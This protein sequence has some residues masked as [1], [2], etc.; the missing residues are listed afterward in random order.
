[1]QDTERSH[2]QL[3]EQTINR[4][5]AW[6]L[7]RLLHDRK[8]HRACYPGRPEI[9]PAAGRQSGRITEYTDTKTNKEMIR[10]IGESGAEYIIPASLHRTNVI[11]Q[12]FRK[13]LESLKG[14]DNDPVHRFVNNEYN[15]FQYDPKTYGIEVL[16]FDEVREGNTPF[17]P[18]VL[19]H[20]PSIP[21]WKLAITLS[22]GNLVNDKKASLDWYTT[23]LEIFNKQHLTIAGASVASQ[24]SMF[25]VRLIK[26]Y[27]LTLA[28]PKAPNA[29]NFNRT[30]YSLIDLLEE[31]DTNDE[32]SKSIALA[33]NIHWQDPFQ[34]IHVYPEGITDEN[35]ESYLSGEYDSDNNIAVPR[36]TMFIE[37]IDQ[38]P[39]KYR[40]LVTARKLDIP[41]I[42]LVDVASR[43]INGFNSPGDNRRKVDLFYGMT[44]KEIAETFA[45]PT[46]ESFV[47]AA[48]LASGVT[49]T[50]ADPLGRAFMRQI[51]RSPFR[52]IPQTGDVAG[53]SGILAARNAAHFMIELYKDP[54]AR[55]PY[56][57]QVFDVRT[58]KTRHHKRPLLWNKIL[59]I[60]IKKISRKL[61]NAR[62]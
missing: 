13:L 16:F 48:M 34:L 24:A 56:R 15:L 33:R 22:N 37:A 51:N 42:Q 7:E 8:H 29:S 18:R 6:N 20:L 54:N 23:R 28:D 38:L 17:R 50:L 32:V 31:P 43:G 39:V 26:P 60:F 57:Q 55:F 45:N 5:G 19:I 52:S 3:W 1:M 10:L 30:N 27:L 11:E 46:P 9:I 53:A 49:N 14:E 40:L 35:M 44:D 59:N 62:R 2:A 36:T 61:L 4:E 47:V 58:C 41:T 25:A 21:V 12:T